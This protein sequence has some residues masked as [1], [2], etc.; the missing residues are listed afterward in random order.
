MKKPRP[1]YAESFLEFWKLYP[2]RYHEAGRPKPGGG[3]EHYWKIGK[4]D[5]AEE[6]DELT[7]YDKRWAMYSVTYIKKGPFVPDASRWLKHGRYEDIDFPEEEGEHLPPSTTTNVFKS[8]PS[9]RVNL[10]DE[11]NR[12]TKELLK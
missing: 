7:E 9:A 4:R 10:N 3:Y 5:A 1:R 6:W 2:G 8:V 11:R 12:Q